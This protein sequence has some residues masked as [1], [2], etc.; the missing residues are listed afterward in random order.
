MYIKNKQ[1]II[2]FA[3]AVVMIAAFAVGIYLPIHKKVKEIRS[4]RE[5]QE[6]MIND[7]AVK[8]NQLPQ[9]EHQLET[10][11]GGQT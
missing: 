8:A 11:C 1:Q 6:L 4:Q 3:A 10:M 7:A 2:I 9:L 5:I